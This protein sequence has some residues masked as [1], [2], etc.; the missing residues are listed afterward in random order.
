MKSH[1]GGDDQTREFFALSGLKPGSEILDMGAGGGASIQVAESFGFNIT[2]VDRE[3]LSEKVLRGDY[4]EDIF[5][6]GSFDGVLS[7]CSFYS[8]GD[9]EKAAAQA[10][11]FLK[12]DGVLMLADIFFEDAKTMLEHSGFE[13]IS[14]KD[15]TP[16]WRKYFL[17]AIWRDSVPDCVFRSGGKASYKSVIC[18]KV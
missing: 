10:C 18:K 8:S 16:L 11:R 2:A 3:P 14:I 6:P 5:E 15:M 4:L 17:E 1:P 7:Q 9:Q 13:V 12:K